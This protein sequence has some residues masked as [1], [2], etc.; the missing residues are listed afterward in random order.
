MSPARVVEESADA[1]L[2]HARHAALGCVRSPQ[3]MVRGNSELRQVI[4]PDVTFRPCE[5]PGLGVL[6]VKLTARPARAP[7]DAEHRPAKDQVE[8]LLLTTP[9]VREFE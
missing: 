6:R 3:G 8:A 1:V 2:R 7:Q 9:S 4:P 5:Y